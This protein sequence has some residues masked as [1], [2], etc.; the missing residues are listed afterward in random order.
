MRISFDDVELLDVILEKITGKSSCV[1]LSVSDYNNVRGEVIRRYFDG[2]GGE[3]TEGDN[4]FSI[5]GIDAT[6]YEDENEED[7]DYS[8]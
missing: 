5:E 1:Y 2:N 7:Y 4:W 8:V 6:F 3:I